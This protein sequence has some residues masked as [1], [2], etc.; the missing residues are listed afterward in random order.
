MEWLNNWDK[1]VYINLTLTK[2]MA[3]TLFAACDFVVMN[4]PWCSAG[5]EERYVSSRPP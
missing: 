2:I 1:I 5:I 4:P 3:I